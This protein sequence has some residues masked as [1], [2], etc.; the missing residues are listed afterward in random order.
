MP[1]KN[2]LDSRPN[3]WRPADDPLD[4]LTA[5]KAELDT[6]DTKAIIFPAQ[7]SHFLY[8]PQ[9]PRIVWALNG[10]MPATFKVTR[11]L[12]PEIV[13]PTSYYFADVEADTLVMYLH[14]VG[15]SLFDDPYHVPEMANFIWCE[16]RVIWFPGLERTEILYLYGY[17]DYLK[18][19]PSAAH[20]RD[21]RDAPSTL[22]P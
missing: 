22:K 13:E 18:R 4:Q 11:L 8:W 7:H 20:S 3:L 10:P 1:S 5:L 21:L 2:P 12:F 16:G 9:G 14:G 19:H 17:D 6:P 15:N